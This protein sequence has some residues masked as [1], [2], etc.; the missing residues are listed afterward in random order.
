[1]S[2]PGPF[3]VEGCRLSFDLGLQKYS[4]LIALIGVARYICSVSVNM[5][6]AVLAN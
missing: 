4:V 2:P 1:M 5:N 3:L 6:V